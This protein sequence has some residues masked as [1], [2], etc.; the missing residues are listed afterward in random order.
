MTEQERQASALPYL[1]RALAEGG[2]SISALVDELAD[3]TLRI[4]ERY[5]ES[6]AYIEAEYPRERA[7]VLLIWSLG[8]VV[9]HKHL[10]RLLGAELTGEP[11]ALLPY[12]RG[13]TD[14]LMNG[15]YT[16]AFK[17]NLRE[18]IAQLETGDT[19]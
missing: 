5:V 12:L 13:A 4:E 17:D 15:L 7:V 9:L 16:E 1:A 3:E 8:A 18:A 6:G 14:L 10:R 11:K 2:A 19:S